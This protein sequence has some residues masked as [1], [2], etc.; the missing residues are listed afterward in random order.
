MSVSTWVDGPSKPGDEE[1]SVH[2]GLRVE[3]DRTHHRGWLYTQGTGCWA[4]GVDVGESRG[5][6]PWMTGHSAERRMGTEGCRFE[7]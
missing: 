2:L 7:V 3:N 5:A 4:D 1:S 6:L